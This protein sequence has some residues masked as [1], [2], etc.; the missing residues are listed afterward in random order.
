MATPAFSM[1]QSATGPFSPPNASVSICA[2]S[3]ASP[4][5]RSLSSHG[6]IPTSFGSNEY[7]LVPAGVTSTTFVGPH[8]VISSKDKSPTVEHTTSAFF[9]PSAMRES[10]IKGWRSGVYTPTRAYWVPAGFSI[11]PS[12]LNAVRTLSACDEE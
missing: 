4:P 9:M 12:M 5:A 3:L 6:G 8:G 2:F 11:G 7:A 1:R 10:A